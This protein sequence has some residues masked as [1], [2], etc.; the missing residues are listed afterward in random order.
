MSRL[1]LHCC[2]DGDCELFRKINPASRLLASLSGNPTNG[3]G[4]PMEAGAKD[5]LMRERLTTAISA[6]KTLMT[7]QKDRD[8]LLC[9]AQEDAT[10]L[11]DELHALEHK[12]SSFESRPQPQPKCTRP[13]RACSA[14]LSHAERLEMAKDEHGRAVERV[15]QIE[16]D[17]EIDMTRRL[18]Q[19]LQGRKLGLIYRCFKTTYATT[20]NDGDQDVK[21]VIK[22]TPR[23]NTD[24]MRSTRNEIAA[25]H[26]LRPLQGT[27]IPRLLDYGR[28]ELDGKRYFA[29]V[30]ERIEDRDL[31]AQQMPD[32]R[33]SIGKL[34]S[35]ERAACWEA[36]KKMHELGIIHRDIRGSNLMF[37]DNL[38]GPNRIPVLIGL[39]CAAIVEDINDQD[40]DWDY[41][42]FEQMFDENRIPF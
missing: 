4:T 22:L 9:S 33:P 26:R 20:W 11:A 1:D 15:R 29:I 10:R 17:I 30:M 25:Y 40:K 38:P 2:A 36:V 3:E 6:V 37:R 31:G 28:T 12:G 32:F 14:A 39:A 16:C 24:Q 42:Y 18:S 19:S 23:N 8:W 27:C 7:L 5:K 21:A 41:A 13:R 34:S 35:Q